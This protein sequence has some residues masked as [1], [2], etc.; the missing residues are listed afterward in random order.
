M[1]R[2]GEQASGKVMA[3]DELAIDG[4]ALEAYAFAYL[5]IRSKLG[6]PLT[7]QQTTGVT[8]SWA[9]GGVYARAS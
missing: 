9:T 7:M 1:K 2:L 8:R 6:L 4:D 5:A 3:I